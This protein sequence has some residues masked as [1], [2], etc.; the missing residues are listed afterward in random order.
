MAGA[1][2]DHPPRLAAYAARAG[3]GVLDEP[4]TARVLASHLL[5]GLD[6][7]ALDTDEVAAAT[8]FDRARI[9]AYATAAT[10]V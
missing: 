7:G 10:A 2:P 8:G 3:G 6:C 5:R 9:E 4:A 1:D